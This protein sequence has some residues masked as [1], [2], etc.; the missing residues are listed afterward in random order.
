ME[1]E[2][3]NDDQFD[4]S[5]E[6]RGL[7]PEPEHQHQVGKNN[8]DPSCQFVYG[9]GIQNYMNDASAD[10]GDREERQQH[11]GPGRSE[12]AAHRVRGL[13]FLDHTWNDKMS[14][15][16][17]YSMTDMDLAPR[18]QTPAPSRRGSYALANVLFTPVPRT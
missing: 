14:S 1:W 2:D 8:V 16:I 17:G 5:G 6:R 4:L 18:P 13:V 7:G 11:R 3:L 10:I 12:G 15:S 9:E